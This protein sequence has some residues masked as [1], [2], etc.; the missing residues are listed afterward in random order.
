M[1]P[2]PRRTMSSLA[3]SLPHS[4]GHT[5]ASCSPSLSESHPQETNCNYQHS[6]PGQSSSPETTMVDF[7][8]LLHTSAPGPCTLYP[9]RPLVPQQGVSAFDSLGSFNSV[10]HKGSAG[11]SIRSTQRRS[12]NRSRGQADLIKNYSQGSQLH[13]SPS[14]RDPLQ[15][16]E[17]GHRSRLPTRRASGAKPPTQPKDGVTKVSDQVAKTRAEIRRARAARNRSSARRSRLR[18]KAENQREKEKA[19]LVEKQNE[20]LKQRV[21]ELRE[22]MLS[23]QKIANALGLVDSSSATE[24]PQSR[25]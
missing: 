5:R 3:S 22:K 15:T 8:M 19:S 12:E 23:L 10:L 17:S 18:K 2:T 20:T 4:T 13:L 25:R 1:Q 14:C 16:S 11:L 9:Y 21:I 6:E 7:E 24:A